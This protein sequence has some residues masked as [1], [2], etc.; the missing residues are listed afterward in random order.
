[1]KC[2]RHKPAKPGPPPADVAARQPPVEKAM[3]PFGID[4]R[5]ALVFRFHAEQELR[6]EA[7]PEFGRHLRARSIRAHEMADALAGTAQLEAATDTAHALVRP[8][9]AQMRTRS[10]GLARE[11]AHERRRIGRAGCRARVASARR[12]SPSARRLP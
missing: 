9:E 6:I 10:P 8:R 2:D 5:D 11:P 7:K 12:E 4:A 1:R 3:Q